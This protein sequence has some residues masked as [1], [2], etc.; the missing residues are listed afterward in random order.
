MVENGNDFIDFSGVM[1][2]N[3]DERWI[4]VK[5]DAGCPIT[6]KFIEFGSPQ[7][8]YSNGGPLWAEVRKEGE[9]VGYYGYPGQSLGPVVLANNG[10]ALDVVIH[11][12]PEEGEEPSPTSVTLRL[13]TGGNVPI[14]WERLIQ[15]GEKKAKFTIGPSVASG[16]LQA[17]MWFAANVGEKKT[18]TIALY[19][20]GLAPQTVQSITKVGAG[21]GIP[22]P[23]DFSL[24]DDGVV[25]IG[26]EFQETVVPPLGIITFEVAF[27]PVSGSFNPTG[28]LYIWTPEQPEGSS[29]TSSVVVNLDGRV[30]LGAQLPVAI[31]TAEGLFVAGDEINLDATQSV[32]GDAEIFDFGYKWF[33]SAKPADSVSKLNE[34]GGES[35]TSFQADK[36]GTYR[37]SLVVAGVVPTT[38]ESHFSDEASVEIVVGE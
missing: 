23:Q 1:P 10:D 20:D 38:G 32:D 5:N 6:L 30:D 33:L 14:D 7:D 21:P 35:T 13:S 27:E 19:N 18:K 4:N 36:P 29:D 11:Y 22:I 34:K 25:V 24:V 28:F 31:P 16:D 2:P 8:L 12:V 9:T 3:E 37:V 15:A 17:H 26:G